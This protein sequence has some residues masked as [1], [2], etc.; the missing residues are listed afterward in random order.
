MGSSLEAASGADYV[1]PFGGARILAGISPFADSIYYRTKDLN[2]KAAAD[3]V[4]R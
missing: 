1:M 3:G 4:L 2:L